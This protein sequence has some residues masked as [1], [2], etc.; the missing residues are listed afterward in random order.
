MTNEQNPQP[1]SQAP[2]TL[3]GPDP[4]SREDELAGSG[5]SG[6]DVF[7]G[8]DAGPEDELA[9]PGASGPG[10]LG[11]PDPGEGAED[12]LRGEV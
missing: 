12:E 1:V 4:G 11:G 5:A 7:G 10:V 3:G 9:E 6:P 8:P 2:D